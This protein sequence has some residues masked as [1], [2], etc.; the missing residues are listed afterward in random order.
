MGS[1]DLFNFT[2]DKA[3]IPVDVVLKHP[4]TGMDTDVVIQIVGVDSTA[5]QECM[6]KQQAERFTAM[7]TSDSVAVSF[8]PKQNRKQLLDLLTACTVGWKNMSYNGVDLEFNSDNARMV[9]ASVPFVRDQ[10]NKA[11]GSRKI[12]FKD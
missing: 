1:I 6:D 5:A 9:Y 7:T 4:V 8:D 3:N 10:I 2:S 12:F 11:T